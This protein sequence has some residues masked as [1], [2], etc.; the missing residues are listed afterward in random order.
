[1]PLAMSSLKSGRG[2]SGADNGTAAA[3][4]PAR[5]ERATIAGSNA[6]KSCGREKV[7]CQPN[8]P[9]GGC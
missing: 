4:A 9:N 7:S 1:M 6:T 8:G 3:F 5:L 2:C